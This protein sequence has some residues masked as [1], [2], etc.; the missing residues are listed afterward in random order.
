MTR[1]LSPIDQAIT[2]VDRAFSTI[3]GNRRGRRGS[4][5]SAAGPAGE[6]SDEERRH[7]AGLMRINHTGEVCAQALYQG[8]EVTARRKDVR[9]AMAEAA[10]EEDDHLDW[11]LKR[12]NELD[13]RVSLLNP[14]WYT[15]SFLIGAGAGLLGD[16]WSLGFVAETER[17][18]VHHL[19]SHLQR[20][21][22][23][24][25]RSRAIIEQMIIDEGRHASQAVEQGAA[26]LPAPIKQGMR[27]TAKLMTGLTY[28]V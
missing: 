16:R 9:A 28:R 20:L 22:E 5:A 7:V 3:F 21:P 24:D 2:R 18:V 19:E 12:L 23:N 14:L 4:P 15:G 27:L 13:D 11:C 17:Q 26:E 6:L 10:D 25:E 8:Q 1:I